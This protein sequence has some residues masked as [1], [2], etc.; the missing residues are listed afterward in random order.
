M[1]ILLVLAVVVTALLGGCGVS[2]TLTAAVASPSATS[3]S[4]TA[5]T[6]HFSMA[7]LAFD[8]PAGWRSIPVERPLHYETVLAFLTSGG[9]NASETC[10]SDYIPGAGGDCSEDYALPV[11]S[12]VVKLWR[13][14][15]PP[16]QRGAIASLRDQ[17]WAILTI[18]GQ[19]AAF[20]SAP[21]QGDA[22]PG[23]DVTLVWEVAAPEPGN[24]VAYRI[25]A[26]IRGPALAPIRGQLEAMIESLQ[27][28]AADASG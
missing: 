7:G 3:S 10:G 5:A 14:D 16:T 19:P 25:S 6:S 17:G 20:T 1:K 2:P 28:E 18:A 23:S 9:A 4:S 21:G 26:T 24:Q 22:I 27:L 12:S 8:Y 13:W 15:G 11:N